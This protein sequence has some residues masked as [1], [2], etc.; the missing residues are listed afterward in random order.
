MSIIALRGF[1]TALSAILLTGCVPELYMRTTTVQALEPAEMTVSQHI[2]SIVIVN[3]TKPGGNV[4]NVLEGLFSGEAIGQDKSG[5]RAWVNGLAAALRNS[6]R[7]EHAVSDIR[8]A[9]G[10]TGTSFSDPLEWTEV[11]RI[12]EAHSVD[13]LVALETYDTD[14]RVTVLKMLEVVKEGKQKVERVIFVAEEVVTVKLGVRF[15]DPVNEDVL[16]QASF[17]HTMTAEGRGAT[18]A[19]ARDDLNG[20]VIDAASHEA[21]MEY[22]HIIAPVWVPVLRRYYTR[23]RKNE[24]MK[25]GA[26]AARTGDWTTAIARWEQIVTE[27]DTKMA[28]L[29]AYNLAVAH[30][31]LG[32]IQEAIVWANRSAT[33]FDNKLAMPYWG[34]LEQRQWLE[35]KAVEQLNRVKDDN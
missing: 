16:D 6:P 15:Y 8:L 35:N 19:Q 3:R 23:F 31:A 22:G 27:G 34:D 4:F 28:G 17:T 24:S 25:A 11:S 7:F 1:A 18:E 33:E 2:Q 29:A 10:G 20:R 21:G 30:E 5:S 26:V 14:S 9:G 12:C 32:N 13:A